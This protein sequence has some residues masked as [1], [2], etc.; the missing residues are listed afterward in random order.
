MHPYEPLTFMLFFICFSLGTL[1]YL[2][3]PFSRY[4]FWGYLGTGLFTLGF[5]FLTSNLVLRTIASGRAPFSNLY[6]SL[7]IFTWG[8]VFFLLMYQY[9]ARLFLLG[10]V[11]APLVVVLLLM[12]AK[13]HNRITDLMPALKSP[14][15]IYHVSTA[16]VAYGAFTVSFGLAVIYLVRDY[17]ERAFPC[18]RLLKDLPS[19]DE[20]DFMIYRAISTGFP[21]M[22][23]LIITGAIWAD[24]AWGSY[25]RW[26][27]K[28]VWSLITVLIY[29]IYF[30]MRFV[31]KL[32]GRAGAV[33]AVAGFLSVAICYL[34]VNLVFAGIHSYGSR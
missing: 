20:L 5:I 19:L 33:I 28:E 34:G 29:S 18:H 23:L 2:L 4:E 11:V 12:A 30:H 7:L 3:F 6:E 26:D 32:R 13:A 31:K 25:W 8:I 10:T 1:S 9:S 22:G 16:I 21:F 14:W 15:M 17:L 24:Y 27:P